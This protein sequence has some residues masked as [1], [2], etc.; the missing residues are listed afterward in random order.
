[1]EDTDKKR[2]AELMAGL[3]QTFRAD[4][5]A[6]D[7]ES[8]WRFLRAYPLKQIEQ[9]ILGYCVSPEG[10]KFMPK[11]GEIVAAL[12]GKESEKSLMAWVKVTKAMKK[13]GAY[14]TVIFDDAIIHAVIDGLGGWIR[15]CL[16]QER[17]LIFQQKEFERLYVCYARQAIFHYPRQ[18]AG[19]FDR[20]NASAGYKIRQNP[21]LCGNIHQAALVFKNGDDTDKLSYRALSVDQIMKLG[22]QALEQKPDD[23]PVKPC[24]QVKANQQEKK[25]DH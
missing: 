8:Y 15:L 16:L 22:V 23:L 2:F 10:H 14:K 21:L 3:A 12:G 25:N 18:L 1:M 13:G 20:D 9:A 19:I 7:I 5:S 4:V 24:H 17:E 11:P 6:Q